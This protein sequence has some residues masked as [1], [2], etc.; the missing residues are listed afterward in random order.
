[1]STSHAPPAGPAEPTAT[2]APTS[3]ADTYAFSA[4]I[5]Q[6]LSLIVN[7]FYTQ[8]DVFLREL[9]SNASDALDKQRF[10][11]ITERCEEGSEPELRID[12]IPDRA[13]KTL[14]IKDTGVG[15]TADDLVNN[16]GTIAKSG[17]KAFMEAAS[18]G[19]DLNMIGQFGVGFYSAFLVAEKVTVTSSPSKGQLES[20]WESTAGGSFTIK[21][22]GEAAQR[23]TAIVLHLKEGMEEYL[24]EDRIRNLVV[25][26]T[27]FISYPIRL[28]VEKTVSE[29]VTDDDTAEDSEPED[30]EGKTS[31][32]EEDNHANEGSVKDANEE[33]GPQKKTKTVTETRVEKEVLNTQ[34]PLW[35][36]SPD[37]VEPVEYATFYKAAASDWED[38]LAVKHFKAEG[39]L[40]FRG[41]LF[42]PARA[43]FDMFS[44]EEKRK[45]NNIKLY[46]RRVF[47]Q[48][49]KPELMPDYL[50]FIHGVVDSDDL[51]L[52]IS[53]E[54][55]QQTRILKVIRK[56]L[57]KKAIEAIES[58]AEDEDP[59]KYEKFYAAFSRNLKLGIHDDRLNRERLTKLLRFQSSYQAPKS[60]GGPSTPALHSFEDY[61][62]RMKESQK[63]IYYVIGESPSM[64]ASSPFVERIQA[65]GFEVLYMTD[66]IDEYSMQQIREYDGRKVVSATEE[67]LRLPGDEEDA[68]K[69]MQKDYKDTCERVKE[70]LGEKVERVTVSLRMENSPCC[71][72][73]GKYG[74][75]ANMQRILKAQALRDAQSMMMVPSKKIMELNPQHLLVRQIHDAAAKEDEPSKRVVMDLVH[76]LYKTALLTSGFTLD[77]PS[78]FADRIHR[79]VANGMGLVTSSMPPPPS[80]AEMQAETAAAAAEAAAAKVAAAPTPQA[81]ETSESENEMEEVD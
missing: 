80:L 45:H 81:N 40:Q 41:L 13:A 64:V 23:G 30:S 29:E 8:K 66:A 26:H 20:T 34:Q 62:G 71:L 7:T 74:Y 6:L 10:K 76:M 24:E 4:D 5:N 18:A 25:K 15:M 28:H 65:R 17:T 67:G 38:H 48:E 39:Q 16:L 78:V 53:R 31:T 35:V 60:E 51:P 52:N 3:T 69:E 19:S 58:I 33:G 1:M 50:S 46:A 77:E 42:I 2:G 11:G 22:E 37:E 43:P 72:V 36:R 27:G 54:T 73:S 56:T 75:S 9:I 63:D 79:L 49:N 14:T 57:V 12:I 44:G 21:S 70:I 59:S 68:E 47:I 61:V 32:P 55:L